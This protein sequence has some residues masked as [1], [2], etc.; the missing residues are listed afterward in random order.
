MPVKNA[1][2]YLEDCLK[3]IL[4]QTEINWELITVNDNSSDESKLI[5]EDFAKRDSRIIALENSGSG[6]INALR[7]AYAKASGN[8][9]TRMDADDLMP[10]NKLIVLK[11]ELLSKGTGHLAIGLVKYFSD[12]GLKDGYRYYESWLNELT[13]SGTN[14]ADIY[15]ECVIPSPCWMVHREDF[16]KCDAFNP[17]TYP[18]D[19][20]L[21]F[22]FYQHNLKVIPCAEVLHQWR[23]HSARTSRNDHNYADNRFLD[24]KLKWF[25]ELDYNPTR[26][27]VI[28]GAASKGKLLVKGLL[29][30]GIKFHWMCNNP[31]KINKH[32]YD[33]LIENV[34]H[35]G[36]LENPQVIIA[37]AN[38]EQQ[39]EIRSKLSAEKAF[40][41]C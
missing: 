33:T 5:L 13:A 30:A 1:G 8:L 11:K 18:E 14:Y 20:D 7:K 40:F 39:A 16:E 38:K 25:L 32:V 15:K 12:E 6:I 24:L 23:D 36:A 22:R 3:S 26:P 2:P 28:W 27:L 31:N 4:N 41:F 21:C 37:V 19:Y 10:I 34:S 35:I 9:I 29:N 17:D